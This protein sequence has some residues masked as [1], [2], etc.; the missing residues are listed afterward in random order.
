MALSI[1]CGCKQKASLQQAQDKDL[2]VQLMATAA[3]AGDSGMVSYQARIIPG[4]TILTQ[5]TYQ[6]KTAMLYQIDSCFYL[7]TNGRK[8]YPVLVQSIANGVAGTYEYLI[9]FEPAP[10]RGSRM[11]Y[12]DKYFTRRKYDLTVTKN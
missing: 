10:A 5:Q 7:Q 8:T 9:E 6:Q 12:Q 11:V 3:V 4:K 1:M 2:T